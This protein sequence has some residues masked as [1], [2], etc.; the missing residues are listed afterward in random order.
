MAPRNR[1]RCCCAS[2]LRSRWI[3]TTTAGF[4]PSYCASCSRRDAGRAPG[5]ACLAGRAGGAPVCSCAAVVSVR[6]LVPLLARY[7][8][9][10]PGPG[11]LGF[12]GRLGAIR[13]P[14]AGGDALCLAPRG[15]WFLA[16]AAACAAALALVDVVDRH[17]LFFW[18][19]ALSAAGGG[20]G[21]N[22][23]GADF[24]RAA[25]GTFAR[26]AADAWAMGCVDHGFRRHPN[27]A[28]ARLVSVSSRGAVAAH[29]RAH[30]R[31]LSSPDAQ[32][33]R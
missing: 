3:T 27:P 9:E 22:F 15:T 23:S 4:C 10:I 1:F 7:H 2:I 21:D 30:Q 8:G 18:R 31:A 11:S 29:H 25:V 5:A 32:T 17:L 33:G 6:G 26:R 20:L 12:P 13:R 28:P 19:A 16:H 14:D 24:H